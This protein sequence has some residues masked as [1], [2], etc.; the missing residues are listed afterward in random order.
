MASW[1]ASLPLDQVVRVWVLAWDIVFSCVL[2]KDTLL[3]HCLS[4]PRCIMALVNFN[5]TYM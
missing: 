3:S 4:P 2:G 1:I 5:G